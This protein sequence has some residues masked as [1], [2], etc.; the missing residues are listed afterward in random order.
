[1]PKSQ[2]SFISQK[3]GYLYA[4]M[5]ALLWGISGSAAKFLFGTGV[6]PFELVQLRLTIAAAVLPAWLLICR[7]ESIKIDLRDIGYFIIL[8]GAMAAVQFTYLFAISKIQ[9][10]IAILLQYLAPSLIALYM[11]A[12]TGDRLSRM[13]LAALAGAFIGCY[14]VVGAFHFNVLVMNYLGIISGFL[15]ALSFAWYSLQGEYG[16]RRYPPWTVLFYALLF[17]AIA[18][19]ILQPP[20]K[21]FLRSYSLLQW[22]WIVH[23]GL[24]GTL[25]P[26]GLYFKGINLIRSTHASITATLEPITAGVLSFVFLNEIMSPLQVAGGIMVIAAVIVLQ[27]RQGFDEKAPDVIRTLRNLGKR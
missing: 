23:I 14:L 7:R 19:N 5:A 8:G 22:Y 20:F 1:M 25:L 6:S 17:G 18:W 10:A 3:R 24:L 11:V 4:V 2:S 16:M 15:S 26:F 21:A 9:V 12:V 27:Y 13:T